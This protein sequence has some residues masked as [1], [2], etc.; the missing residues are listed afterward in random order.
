[1]LLINYYSC[2]FFSA[3][4]L[5]ESNHESC[6]KRSGNTSLIRLKYHSHLN[7]FFVEYQVVEAV[8]AH[9]CMHSFIHSFIHSFMHSFIH[10]FIHSFIHSHVRY[11]HNIN[12]TYWV[13]YFT[14]YSTLHICWQLWSVNIDPFRGVKVVASCGF[15]IR[16]KSHL[17]WFVPFAEPMT[18]ASIGFEV[19]RNFEAIPTILSTQMQYHNLVW[20]PNGGSSSFF[21]MHVQYLYEYRKTPMNICVECYINKTHMCKVSSLSSHNFILENRFFGI[22][23][24][25]T[26]W[27][28][29]GIVRPILLAFFS[30][31]T[32]M[33]SKLRLQ[34]QYCGG[35]GECVTWLDLTNWHGKHA[36]QYESNES[37]VTFGMEAW[38]TLLLFVLFPFSPLP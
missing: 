23:G 15:I 3:R 32:N 13:N 16:L 12:I 18:R 14:M 26:C 8:A 20:L 31:S 22:L 34:V 37:I 25:K 17:T 35:W 29:F 11:K 24:Y 7:K 1:M 21:C 36:N 30:T 6:K 2:V 28:R 33:S 38:L 19:D 4:T 10:A 9:A 5:V 27:M